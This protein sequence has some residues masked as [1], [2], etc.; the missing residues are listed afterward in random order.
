MYIGML[1]LFRDNDIDYW[2]KSK[3][4]DCGK[5]ENFNNINLDIDILDTNQEQSQDNNNNN[6]NDNDIYNQL[7]Y[8]EY[9]EKLNNNYKQPKNNY[10]NESTYYSRNSKSTQRNTRTESIYLSNNKYKLQ[11]NRNKVKDNRIYD[12]Q[13]TSQYNS[14][15]KF[16]SSNSNQRQ[17]HNVQS[18]CK[19]YYN[20]SFK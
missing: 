2:I 10:N 17:M 7:C 5:S 12:L 16:T 3:I 19:L 14:I 4:I 15:Y 11:Y 6:D 18:K 1:Q 8:D 20:K 13:K 9:S